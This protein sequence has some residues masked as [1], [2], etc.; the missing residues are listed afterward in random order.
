VLALQPSGGS[1][2]DAAMDAGYAALDS[3]DTT[4]LHRLVVLS[5]GYP[6]VSGDA[7]DSISANILSRGQSG[8]GLTM[9]GVLLGWDPTVASLLGKTNG[10]NY[11]YLGDLDHVTQVFDTDVD[12]I[13]SPLAY[14]L[15]LGLTLD[16]GWTLDRMYGIP[17]NADGTPAA[18]FDV[19]TVFP[20]RR[21]G[22]IVARLHYT[23]GDAPTSVGSVAF[24][25]RPEPA[26]GYT[27]PV[28]ESTAINLGTPNADGT[29]FESPGVRKAAAL[30]NEATQLTAAC[31][32]WWGNDHA[33]ALQKA[34]TLRDYL[35]GENAVLKDSALD[36]EIALVD[37]LIADMNAGGTGGTSGAD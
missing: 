9:V 29:Y 13:L 16:G 30:V 23:G 22:S 32:A 19:A 7:S 27:G 35:A 24:S 2:I 28:S 21:R 25:Y 10:A 20:S 1:N 37:K 36:A 5:C 14:D 6:Y 26:L 17:G 11:Y 33:G 12:F 4:R 18:S 34:Q 8:I 31:D 15:A 3:T